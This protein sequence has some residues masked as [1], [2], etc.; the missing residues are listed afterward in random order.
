MM[1]AMAAPSA[2]DADHPA[3]RLLTTALADGRTSRL[4]H[5][6][7]EEREL[8]LFADADV[9]SVAG[10]GVL[11]VE[12]ELHEGVA[13]AE[14][15]ARVRDHLRA[16]IDAPLL[17]AELARARA[18]LLAD[19]VFGNEQAHQQALSLGFG[20]TLFGD[21]TVAERSLE[22]AIAVSAEEVQAVAAR[23]FDLEKNPP[24]VG[25]AVPKG[26]RKRG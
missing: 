22:A 16:V 1:L 12:A 7:V 17:P 19:W 25:W 5:D 21:D 2:D 26:K 9:S 11:T 18:A 15:E 14:V 20:L 8:C 24:V 13:P 6:L 10:P 23:W 3:L 4:R